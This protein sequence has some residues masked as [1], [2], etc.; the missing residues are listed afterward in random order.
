M[1][2]TTLFLAM[3]LASP[4]GFACTACTRGNKRENER[5]NGTERACRGGRCEHCLL[6]LL[7][8]PTTSHERPTAVQIQTVLYCAVLGARGD[9]QCHLN[10]DVGAANTRRRDLAVMR[11]A[12]CWAALHAAAAGIVTTFS[13]MSLRRPS[14]PQGCTLLYCHCTVLYCPSCSE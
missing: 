7:D 9:T 3:F 14:G 12:S 8:R 10:A 6:L 5:E 11:P 1:A 13:L 2:T 4:A